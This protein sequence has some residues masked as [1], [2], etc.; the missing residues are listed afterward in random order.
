MNRFF[1]MPVDDTVN[2]MQLAS[3]AAKMKDLTP[4]VAANYL[5]FF[6]L[7]YFGE[8]PDQTPVTYSETGFSDV[9]PAEVLDQYRKHAEVR[10]LIKGEE[11]L[12]VSDVLEVGRRIAVQFR[13]HYGDETMLFALFRNQDVSSSAEH[14]V[15]SVAMDL[16]DEPPP[17]DHFLWWVMQSIH[18]AARHHC[19]DV[20]K[21]LALAQELDCSLLTGSDFT[22]ALLGE[23]GQQKS[24]TDFTA[25]CVL[26]LDLPY[27]TDISVL[28]LMSVREHDGGT[29]QRFRA[30]LESH[31]RELRAETDPAVVQAKAEDVMHELGVVQCAEIQQQL[32]R[33]KKTMPI[34]VLVGGLSATLVT[35]G[36]SVAALVLALASGY[37][38][39]S[40]Y[41]TRINLNPAY[42][43]WRAGASGKQSER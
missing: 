4:M 33:L 18:Q 1:D 34:S 11:G 26:N 10:S 38:A 23:S 21:N 41:R 13:G 36:F 6:P 20:G 24:I 29:F 27:I 42:F 28:D 5:K 16:P 31:L 32:D 2:R 35:G 8:A 40:E 9:L 22:Y 3:A 25:N 43:L 12:V 14:N 17:K 39:Y 19:E 7:S 30:E 37:P 15:L